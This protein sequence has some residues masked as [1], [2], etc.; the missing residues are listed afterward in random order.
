[1]MKLVDA[2]RVAEILG[3][4]QARTYELAR[5]RI[6]PDGVVVR[7]GRQIRFDEQSLVEWIRG[8]GEALPGGWRRTPE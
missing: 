5:T 4:S 8:G 3:V 2:G 6:L 1:M 7:L